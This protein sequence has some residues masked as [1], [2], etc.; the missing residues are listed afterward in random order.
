[1]ASTYKV[2]GQVTGSAANTNLYTVPS[3][4]QAVVSSLVV[5]NRSAAAKTYRVMIRPDGATLDNKHYIAY[6]VPIS[7]ND[8]IALTL[9]IAL[10]A[11]DVI[12]VYATDSNL[13]FTAF[14]S[15]IT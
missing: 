12:D 10:D 4:T 8:S 14:G 5:C 2:L 9:G 3:A 13:S 1:M 6:D 11:S 15:E 7:A